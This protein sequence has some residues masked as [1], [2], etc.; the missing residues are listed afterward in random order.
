MKHQSQLLIL[1]LLQAISLFR[2]FSTSEQ[3]ADFLTLAAYEILAG[4]DT[5]P[6][7]SRI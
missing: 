3:L 7:R 5:Q 1:L 2:Q 4:A 6:P